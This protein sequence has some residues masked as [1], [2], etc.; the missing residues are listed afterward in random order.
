MEESVCEIQEMEMRFFFF[1]F[2]LLSSD[3]LQRVSLTYY[4]SGWCYLNYPTSSEWARADFTC[5]NGCAEQF[6][7]NAHDLPGANYTF[8]VYELQDRSD[9]WKEQWAEGW[10]RVL[11]CREEGSS[12]S[13]SSILSWSSATEDITST[14]GSETTVTTYTESTSTADTDTTAST[15]EGS[16]SSLSDTTTSPSST[17]ASATAS[18]ASELPTNTQDSAAGRL[19]SPFRGIW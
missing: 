19:R 18:L 10:D 1:F 13:S 11:E 12:S 17:S 5:G 16:T 9:W 6:F 3:F 8:G 14:T 7:A 4:S 15:T 2:S